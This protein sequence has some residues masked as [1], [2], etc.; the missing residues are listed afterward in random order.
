MYRIENQNLRVEI[1]AVGAELQSIYDKEMNQEILWQGDKT[2]WGRRSP[3]LFPNV[4]R[5]SE[6]FYLLKGK[7]Y[8][9]KQ[10]GFA[11]DMEFTCTKESE[12]E[13]VFSLT[14]TEKTRE[15]FPFAFELQ[16]G[17]RL[18]GRDLQVSWEVANKG[19]ETMFF[20]IGGHPAFRAPVLENTLQ[21]EYKLLFKRDV[22]KYRLICPG[23]GT[24][25]TS[26][27]YELPLEKYG[28]YYGCE[29]GRH[30]F[31]QDALLFDE[32]QINWAALGYPDGKPYVS[33]ECPDFPNFG[34]WSVPGA[35]FVCL[36]PWMGRCD[37][38]GFSG[39]ISEKPG[40][41]KTQPGAKFQS[42]YKIR[43]FGD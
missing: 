30:R 40:V 14:D 10:H 18:S 31:D 13:I 22:L 37:A 43:I 36:E 29:I 8:A 19:E 21:E 4:G 38:H 5:H 7:K 28:E 42:S 9:T 3:V 39:E 17:Y 12:E 33:L 6:D 41:L 32:G 23:E 34:I 15:Y 20:T 2:Y 26:R 24:A 16:I 11:R 1:S 35:R 27:S 25:D